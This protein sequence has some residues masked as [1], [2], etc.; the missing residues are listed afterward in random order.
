MK[1]FVK[2]YENYNPDNEGKTDLTEYGERELELHVMNDE[3][4]YNRRFRLTKAEL[5]EM[6]VFTDDQWETLQQT[7]EEEASE[8]EV[9]ESKKRRGL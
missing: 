4:L 1:R 5:E 3:Y 7:I 8:E 6:F 2:L 9:S